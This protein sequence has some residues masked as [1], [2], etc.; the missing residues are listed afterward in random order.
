MATARTKRLLKALEEASEYRET[1]LADDADDLPGSERRVAARALRWAKRLGEA[2]S[3][4]EWHDSV[5][6]AI[7]A[8]ECK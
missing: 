3:G 1:D 6:D 4:D 8:L 2:V 7:K 5:Q